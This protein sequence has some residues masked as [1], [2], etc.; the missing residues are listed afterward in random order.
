MNRRNIFFSL[1]SVS[2]VIFASYNWYPMEPILTVHLRC[3]REISG[4]L[5]ANM[6]L[7]SGKSEQAKSFDIK[8]VCKNGKVEFDDYQ[9]EKTVK[10]TFTYNDDKKY[11]II[12]KYGSEIQS[13]Q[14]GYYLILKI[15]NMLPF[16]SNDRI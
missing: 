11:Q 15:T 5:Q 9:K 12:S 13:D 16:I 4:S 14:N 3:D 6:I 8:E 2:V 7:P 10:F 1:I